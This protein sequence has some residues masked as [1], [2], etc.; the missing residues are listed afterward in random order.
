M[1]EAQGSPRVG[2]VA[3]VRKRRALVTSVQEFQTRSGE[4]S[5]LVGVEYLDA[6]GSRDDQ[7][8]W[9][10][11]PISEVIEPRS[12]PNVEATQP[13]PLADFDAVERAARWQALSPFVHAADDGQS[14]R[15]PIASPLFGAIQVEDFQLKPLV[16]A[17]NMPRVSL[18][19]ADDVGLGKSIEGGLILSELIRRR[20]I[21]RV[22]ILCPAWLRH[23]WKEEMKSKF[24]LGFE[25]VDRAE[26]HALRKRLGMD[27]NPWRTFQRAIASYHYLKQPDVLEQFEAV[28]RTL[29]E[30]AATLPFDLLIVDEAHNVMPSNLGED[31]ALSKAITRIARYFEHKLFLTATPHNG[32]TRCFSGLLEQ[33]DP[34][35][36][37]KKD[38]LTKGEQERV[39]EIVI[40]RLKSKINEADAGAG[41]TPRFAERKIEPLPLV[42]GDLEKRLS[43]ALEK[44]RS[45][46]RSAFSAGSRSEQRTGYFATEILNKRL[47]SCPYAFAD[48]WHRFK[49]GLAEREEANETEVK[50]VQRSVGE[51]SDDDAEAEARAR[52]A[53]HVVGAWL[54]KKRQLLASYIEDIDERLDR[55]GLV[56]SSDGLLSNPVEDARYA[57]LRG[58]IQEK[59]RNGSSWSDD[60]RL[61]IFTE[62][63]TSLDYIV[64]RLHEDF[65]KEPEDRFRVLY[66][67]GELTERHR[68]DIKKAFNDPA[69]PVRVLTA[70]DAASEGQNLQETARL[71][72]H[73]DI[74]WNPS[75]LDQRN[76]RLDRHGQARDVYV[77]H[78][79][80][81]DNA[82]L[83]FLSKVL[84]KVERIRT[85]LGAV[86]AL[87]DAAF[88]RR[89][90]EQ[91]DADTVDRMLDA[92]I[93]KK[94]RK[95]KDAIPSGEIQADAEQKALAQLVK[96]LDFNPETLR[97]TLEVALGMGVGAF[98][99]DGPDHGGR[100]RFPGNLP[101]KWKHLVDS[102]LRLPSRDTNLGPLPGLVFDPEKFMLHRNGRSVFRPAKDAV[103]FSLGHPV[104][105]QALLLLSRARYPG[106]EESQWF[107]RWTVRYGAV[108]AG[109]QAVVALTVEEL[110][111]NELREAFHHWVRT[112][113]FP[114]INGDLGQR[115]PHLPASEDQRGAL[116]TAPDLVRKARDLWAEVSP[117]VEEFL[118][119]HADAL[120]QQ[121]KTQLQADLRRETDTQKALFRTRRQEIERELKKQSKDIRKLMDEVLEEL[122]QLDLFKEQ[123]EIDD[124]VKALEEELQ[125]HRQHHEDMRAFLDQEEKRVLEQIL[126]NRHALRGSVQVMP[127]VVEI[128]LPEGRA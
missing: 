17:L 125:R 56:P 100:Y 83:K 79:T 80:S 66:G 105:H 99:F 28:C 106:T 35:R 121:A 21:R 124:S 36:F 76:G 41:R 108:P 55:L 38:E 13:M 46:V 87:F 94:Q 74:P 15:L 70:T 78:F 3:V 93:A 22:L 88:E 32:Y 8:L 40:R 65:P 44:F 101:P 48:S 126:P 103:L 119:Q 96:E 71:L 43:V 49:A 47:L 85:D 27:A 123:K 18:L 53:A 45:A 112:I 118:T 115:L 127:V 91:R 31:S 60:E 26:T 57:R 54:K 63:K 98:R 111:A 72:L 73:F 75:R 12:L 16:K 19:L 7:L 10:R 92:D 95:A 11:E 128:R 61:I 30:G 69:D 81:E 39:S 97:A 24:N 82:D 113:H 37:T 14:I 110:A 120:T 20:R 62:Y 67:G 116:V 6:D 107:S 2:M 42:F 109:A 59:L 5:R 52:H 1:L 104:I 9:E 34:V 64:R 77:F 86:S 117:E 84:S 68:E 90:Q 89:F 51:D 50:A 122:S 25:I 29:H 102:E 23:Q 33:L 58:L 4:V 114:V